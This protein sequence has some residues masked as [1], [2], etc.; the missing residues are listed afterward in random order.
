M[1]ATR[2]QDPGTELSS[3]VTTWL[4]PHTGFFLLRMPTKL[5]K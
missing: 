3:I 1:D 2:R 5:H 4:T